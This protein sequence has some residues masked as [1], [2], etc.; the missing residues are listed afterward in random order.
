MAK[1]PDAYI[2][3]G[4]VIIPGRIAALLERAA[5]LDELR[6]KARGRDPEFDNVMLALHQAAIEWRTSTY[7][8]TRDTD[9][10]EERTSTW[11]GTSSAANQLGISRRAIQQ[12]ID[13]QRLPA[14]MIENRWQID[15]TDLAQYKASRRTP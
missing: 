6:T 9:G 2:H 13:E 5:R 8:S 1:Q 12:A 14:Q 4:L 7:G 10:E 3:A 11:V 15:R